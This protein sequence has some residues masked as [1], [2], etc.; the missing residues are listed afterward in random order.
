M[1]I[2]SIQITNYKSYRESREVELKTGCNVIT[3]QNNT[4][5]TALLEA[6]ALQAGNKPHRSL[7]TVPQAGISPPPESVVRVSLQL[8]AEEVRRLIFRPGATYYLPIPKDGARFTG[9]E[10]FRY[11]SGGAEGLFSWI[12]SQT[13]FSVEVRGDAIHSSDYDIAPDHEF[14]V[15]DIQPDGN[16]KTAG[17]VRGG[18][19]SPSVSAYLA[20]QYRS[21]TYSFRAERFNL[22]ICL[23][24][25]NT[26]LHPNAAN[27]AE[28]LSNLQSDPVRFQQY[29][30]SLRQVLPQIRQITVH[31][32]PD[33][34]VEILV[35]PHDPGTR[36]P[37]LA[38]P[39]DEC[40]TGVGQV[41]AMLYVVLNSDQ[42][43]TILIDEPQSFLHPG[44]VRKLIEVFRANPQHQYILT[45]HSPTVIAAANPSTI[46]LVTQHE[47]VSDLENIDPAVNE[48]LRRYLM[49]IGA[50]LSDAFG[51]DDIL[52][53]EGPTEELGF[54]IILEK[55]AKKPLLGT[56]ITAVSST[57]DLEGRHAKTAFEIYDR[58][59][60]SK[61][62]PLRGWPRSG[63]ADLN[64]THWHNWHKAQPSFHRRSWVLELHS[65]AR[66]RFSL[67]FLLAMSIVTSPACIQEGDPACPFADDPL[68]VLS[69][70]IDGRAL[71]LDV[72]Y[73]G[74]C[75]DHTYQV[76][77]NGVSAP[78]LPPIIPLELQH[79]ANDDSCQALL[80]KTLVIDLQPLDA[81]AAPEARINVVMGRG[82]SV[83]LADIDYIVPTTPATPI[84]GSLQI[85]TSCGTIQ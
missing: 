54:P 25:T 58:I 18:L 29:N 5:K 82:G 20:E 46:T 7:A 19:T 1:Y 23:V 12:S 68:T 36:R 44:A 55:V 69:A 51:A 41:L 22:G 11:G 33:N 76:W 64:V 24:G 28:V 47:G 70:R 62:S 77:W 42:P 75:A 10:G 16:P 81:L 56:A 17:R 65:A 4:G 73:G 9:E 78:S 57:G 61:G 14:V 32:R 40:G 34:K 84:D 63:N 43:R 71:E 27:L 72:Q 85:N 59:S 3:G 52:W 67:W 6:L 49:D 48:E 21:T 30:E 26:V 45:T 8:D 38:I 50:R 60:K 35:W 13:V 74:G 80:Q 37:D 39:L 79:E 83:N 53:V 15:T 2:A 31:N 66:M